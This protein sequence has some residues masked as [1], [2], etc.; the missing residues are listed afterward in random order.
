MLNQKH[1]E[2]ESSILINRLL[3]TIG[4]TNLRYLEIGLEFGT[5]FSA[6]KAEVKTGVDPEPRVKIP[7]KRRDKVFIEESDTFFSKNMNKFDLIF[8]D[9]LHTFDQTYRDLRNSFIACTNK[10]VIIV[11]DTVPSDTFSAMPDALAAYRL[12]EEAGI[13]NTGAWHGDVFKIPLML[14]QL[15]LTG[16]NYC[17]LIDLGNP[18]TVVWTANDK[19]WP[20]LPIVP[21]K[22]TSSTKF[23]HV[24]KNGVPPQFNPMSTE[25]LLNL[26][27][28][29]N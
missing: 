18:K 19:Q 23:E 24:F 7:K 10:S 28:S 21:P 3:L 20:E 14:H 12:R 1:Q 4:V 9:G 2:T 8:L 27:N 5:T 15:K 22:I 6:V 26:L 11:D 29:L 13:V 25:K 17:T 16:V